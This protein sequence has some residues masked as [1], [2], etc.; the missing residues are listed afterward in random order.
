MIRNVRNILMLNTRICKRFSTNSERET[1]LSGIKDCKN[2]K[3][4][5]SIKD[6]LRSIKDDLLKNNIEINYIRNDLIGKHIQ[7]NNISSTNSENEKLLVSIKN[8]LIKN[9]S[10]DVKQIMMY[11][12]SGLMSGV[13]F[14][15]IVG[16]VATF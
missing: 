16:V 12:G 7:I 9:N 14:I 5:L 4:L 11:M 10:N 1:V 6:D 15:A 2:E 3:L 8:I 13:L